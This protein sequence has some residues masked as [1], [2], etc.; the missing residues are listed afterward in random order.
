MNKAIEQCKIALKEKE[1]PVGCV[2]VHIPTKKILAAS[3]NLTN[4]SKNATKHAEINCFEFIQNL[5]KD[6]I[7][8]N[9]FLKRNHLDFEEFKNLTYIFSQ[10]ALFVSCEPCI[11]CSYA[12]SIMSKIIYNFLNIFSFN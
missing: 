2:F 11:M 12:L 1:V 4:K 9:E 6:Q 7:L 8:K 3:H 5:D 10:S